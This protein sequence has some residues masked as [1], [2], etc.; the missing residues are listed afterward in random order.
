M[1]GLTYFINKL[2]IFV[3][4]IH[5]LTY[6]V[7]FIVSGLLFFIIKR[8]IQ[9]FRPQTSNQNAIAAALTIFVGLPVLGLILLFI[10]ELLLKVCHQPDKTGVYE[11]FQ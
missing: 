6:L 5:P 8:T 4:S 7:L 11:Y 3:T 9:K 10:V 2:F 1:N